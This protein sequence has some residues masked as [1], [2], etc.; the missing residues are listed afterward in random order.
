[1]DKHSSLAGRREIEGEEIHVL[2]YF[3]FLLRILGTGVQ[4]SVFQQ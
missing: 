2:N 3:L 4:L 1:M